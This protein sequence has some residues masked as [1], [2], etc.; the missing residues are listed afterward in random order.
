MDNLLTIY[1]LLE[2]GYIIPNSN[3]VSVI[4]RVEMIISTNERKILNTVFGVSLTDVLYTE[5]N[6]TTPTDRFIH[7]W[8]GDIV[9]NEDFA[10]AERFVANLIYFLLIQGLQ[11][12]FY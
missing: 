2:L 1:R 6:M 7:L 4:E 10:G 9:D 3:D 5:G 11:Y 12:P 8:S